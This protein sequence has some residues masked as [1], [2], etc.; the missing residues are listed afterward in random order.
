MTVWG[1]KLA[2]ACGCTNHWTFSSHP[3]MFI[4]LILAASLVLAFLVYVIA[5]VIS[6]NF[7]TKV[8]IK[9]NLRSKKKFISKK[10]RKV[11]TSLNLEEKIFETRNNSPIVFC[12]GFLSP[13]ICISSVLVKKLSERELRAVLLH[14]KHHLIHN[15]TIKLFIVKTISTTLFFVPG[16]KALSNQYHKLSEV[17]ADEWAIIN[18]ANKSYL[19]RAMYKVLRLREGLGQSSNLVVA[20]FGLIIEERINKITDDNYVIKINII[21]S[22][23][24]LNSFVMLAIVFIFIFIFQT[25]NTA[26]AEQ[27]NGV[28][29]MN[30]NSMHQDCNMSESSQLCNMEG[31]E[32]S[33]KKESCNIKMQ[34]YPF[35]N[36]MNQNF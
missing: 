29:A 27:E 23:F 7:R 34:K 15:E 35:Y 6:L 31:N 1:E 10:I 30:H 22:N 25:S 12:Y 9:N 20:S 2:A 14:E 19:A 3:W 36:N 8:F 28:C 32:E 21:K 16:I 26:I 13:K 17:S 11:A 33:L 18:S 4:F 24:L 5:K